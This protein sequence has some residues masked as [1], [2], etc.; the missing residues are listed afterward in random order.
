MEYKYDVFISYSSK[1]KIIA[2]T[3]CHILEEHNI[4]CWIAPRDVKPGKPYAREIIIG[5]KNSRIMV[6]VYTKNTNSSQHVSNEIAQ[7][8]NEEKTIIPFLIDNTPM[9]DD[10]NYYLLRT[11]WL[12]AYPNYAKNF[13]HLVH[14]VLNILEKDIDGQNSIR[15]NT[16]S[17]KTDI[18]Y[19]K[20]KTTDWNFF[21]NQAKK[22]VVPLCIICTILLIEFFIFFIVFDL[23]SRSQVWR[24]RLINYS[25]GLINRITLF[26]P[27]QCALIS[28]ISFYASHKI[29]NKNIKKW[30]VNMAKACLYVVIINVCIRFF[31]LISLDCLYEIAFSIYITCFF[32]IIWSLLIKHTNIHANK[33]PF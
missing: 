28:A 29:I 25:H 6:L 10:L 20:Y 8:F 13:N 16:I 33:I 26:F 18:I 32:Y 15:Q 5:I 11:H 24:S 27:T 21:L 30:A 14:A 4:S 19:R 31:Y 3:L 17:K 7:A 2:D 1:D 9:T 22:I 12:V 23:S